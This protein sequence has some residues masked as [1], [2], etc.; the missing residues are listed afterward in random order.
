MG[1]TELLQPH[2]RRRHHLPHHMVRMEEKTRLRGSERGYRRQRR[3]PQ[4]RRTQHR[5]RKIWQGEK[6]I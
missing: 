4:G 3:Y 5:G 6:R 1:C 2:K